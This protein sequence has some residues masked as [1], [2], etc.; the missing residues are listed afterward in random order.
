MQTIIRIRKGI[1]GFKYSACD[2]EGYFIGNFK[3]LADIRRYWK[4]DIKYKN[5]LLI[6]ELDKMPDLSII[7]EESRIIDKILNS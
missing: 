7:N 6:K 1:N 2:Q 5:I 4:I 3:T